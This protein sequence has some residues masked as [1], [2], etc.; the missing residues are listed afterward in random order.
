MAVAGL[1]FAGKLCLSK[2]DWTGLFAVLYEVA[3]AALAVAQFVSLQ[4]GMNQG[5]LTREIRQWWKSR[6]GK[7]VTAH[8][9]GTGMGAMGAA[10]ARA[11]GSMQRTESTEE[12]LRLIWQKLSVTETMLGKLEED[13]KLQR[14]DFVKRLEVVRSEARTLAEEAEQRVSRSITSAPLQTAVGLWLILLGLGMQVWLAVP[15]ARIG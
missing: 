7:A 2:S 11:S 15:P 6:P 8:G 4:N 5:W 9:S 12:Q 10:R 13:I 1:I 3:G 14:E